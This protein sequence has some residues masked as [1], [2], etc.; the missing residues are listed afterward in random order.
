ML[1]RWSPSC[2]TNE[3]YESSWRLLGSL[4][5]TE[6]TEKLTPIQILC[7]MDSAT[8]QM[9]FDNFWS[10]TSLAKLLS[11]LPSKNPFLTWP[12]ALCPS[13]RIHLSKTYIFVPRSQHALDP[14]NAREG[15][16]VDLNDAVLYDNAA[17]SESFGIEDEDP[18]DGD[19]NQ[20]KCWL[21]LNSVRDVLSNTAAVDAAVAVDAENAR[22]VRPLPSCAFVFQPFILF[23]P[24]VF[25]RTFGRALFVHLQTQT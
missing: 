24:S 14:T 8:S 2:Q 22:S 9:S 16:D 6:I 5:N 12:C 25:C 15:D 11:G 1:L 10:S 21:Y 19:E 4:V 18:V 23:E 3:I 13:L 17:K 20:R 7:N